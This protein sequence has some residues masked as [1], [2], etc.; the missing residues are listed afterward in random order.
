MIQAIKRRV[1]MCK[2]K[3]DDIYSWAILVDGFPKWTGMSRSEASWRKDR[4]T[5]E[6]IV[7]NARAI[8]RDRMKQHTDVDWTCLAQSIALEWQ[9]NEAKLLDNLRDAFEGETNGT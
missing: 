1:R 2:H 6:L 9:V 5:W 4:E 8:V 3:G 7:A